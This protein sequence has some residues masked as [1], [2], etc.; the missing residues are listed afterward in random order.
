MLG[1]GGVDIGH[2]IG[3]HRHHRMVGAAARPVRLEM[4]LAVGIAEAGE[5]M[6]LL[7]GQRAIVPMAAMERLGIGQPG[8]RAASRR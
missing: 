3:Q 5:E 2:V 1:V 7:E 4:E 8:A 6:R